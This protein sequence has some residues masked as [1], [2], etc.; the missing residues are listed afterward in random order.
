MTTSAEYGG[1]PRD[2]TSI[3][4]AFEEVCAVDYSAFSLMLSHVVIPLMLQWAHE[5]I[6]DEWLPPMARARRLACFGQTEPD[7]GSDAGAI[8]TRAVREGDA[9][10]IEMARKRP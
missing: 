4:I 6:R 10:V 5:D 3:G 9:Y 1:N 7:C 2:C 8:K